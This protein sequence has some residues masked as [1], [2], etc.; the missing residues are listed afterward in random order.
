MIERHKK[1]CTERGTCNLSVIHLTEKI[2]NFVIRM[3]QQTQWKN[4]GRQELKKNF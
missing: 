1:A 2:H 3:E 4:K